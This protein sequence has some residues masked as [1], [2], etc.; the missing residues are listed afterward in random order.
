[1]ISIL[2]PPPP[3]PSPPPP[4]IFFFIVLFTIRTRLYALIFCNTLLTF[5]GNTYFRHRV[6]FAHEMT[7][8]P[9][10]DGQYKSDLLFS[11]LCLQHQTICN[12]VHKN[13]KFRS[14]YNKDQ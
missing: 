10:F 14:H 13:I 11:I 3:P 12:N 9:S 2:P 7:L 6:H 1:M 4:P 5:T 8:H